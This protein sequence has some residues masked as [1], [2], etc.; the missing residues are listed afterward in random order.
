MRAV[1]RQAKLARPLTVRKVRQAPVARP[2]GWVRCP[3]ARV[4]DGVPKVYREAGADRGRVAALALLLLLLRLL[5]ALSRSRSR[6]AGV[7]VCDHHVLSRDPVAE[8]ARVAVVWV[9]ADW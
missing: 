2:E 5:A 1:R 3:L 8:P 4:V 7:Y 6:L 9:F